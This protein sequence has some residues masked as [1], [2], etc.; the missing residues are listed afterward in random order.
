M[1]MN[2]KTPEP[3]Y[4]FE[5]KFLYEYVETFLF[6]KIL[7]KESVLI[8]LSKFTTPRTDVVNLVNY[9]NGAYNMGRISEFSKF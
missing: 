5:P 3:V 4:K 1:K 9:L 2:N 8:S 6:Y 7:F